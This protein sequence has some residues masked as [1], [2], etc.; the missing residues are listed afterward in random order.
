MLCSEPY[1]CCLLMFSA[2][3]QM[4]AARSHQGCCVVVSRGTVLRIRGGGVSK[5]SPTHSCSSFHICGFN[6][7]LSRNANV[8]VSTLARLNCRVRRLTSLGGLQCNLQCSVK[9]LRCQFEVVHGG[10]RSGSSLGSLNI[11]YIR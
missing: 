6:G 2:Y 7:S 4:T 10:Q 5:Y 9:S 11:G 8:R 1:C 3:S